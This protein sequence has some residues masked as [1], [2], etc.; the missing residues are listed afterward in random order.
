MHPGTG[1]IQSDSHCKI[2]NLSL[3][4]VFLLLSKITYLQ[5]PDIRKRASLKGPCYAHHRVLISGQRICRCVQGCALSRPL[6]GEE[7]GAHL[8]RWAECLPLPAAFSRSVYQTSLPGMRCIIVQMD[9]G[10]EPACTCGF[11]RIFW[12][13]R[14]LTQKQTF[15]PVLCKEVLSGPG[16]KHTNILIWMV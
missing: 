2:L 4:T 5:V 12:L 10:Q 8:T 9:L 3:F 7:A 14:H 15:F 11:I 1:I 6:G 16:N 13:S